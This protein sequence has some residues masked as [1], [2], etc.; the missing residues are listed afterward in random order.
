MV[1]TVFL[2]VDILTMSNSNK[3]VTLKLD[4][5]S[6]LFQ[7]ANNLVSPRGAKQ[8]DAD[9][10]PRS[11]SSSDVSRFDAPAITTASDVPE[12]VVVT[13]GD[14]TKHQLG[15]KTTNFINN[16]VPSLWSSNKQM[17]NV[18]RHVKVFNKVKDVACGKE[19]ALFLTGMFIFIVGY[20]IR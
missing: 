19:H 12:N 8:Q 5:A 18:P 7:A 15:V 4:V 10:S 14:N 2:T 3:D 9:K 6:S 20:K 13:F 16:M 17:S 11:R 1:A